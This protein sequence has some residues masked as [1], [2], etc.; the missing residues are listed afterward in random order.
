MSV[1]RPYDVLKGTERRELIVLTVD[2]VRYLAESGPGAD[3]TAAVWVCSKNTVAGDLEKLE[4]L[5]DLA[6]PGVDGAGL[7]SLFA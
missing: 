7:V 5:P 3:P 6:A 1:F 2:G 4:V